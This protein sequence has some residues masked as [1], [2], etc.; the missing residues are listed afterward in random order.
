MNKLFQHLLF[1]SLNLQHTKLHAQHQEYIM[2][3][4]IFTIHDYFLQD[5]MFWATKKLMSRYS[6]HEDG[7][8]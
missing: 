7:P 4:M 1:I 3:Y 5:T 8:A 2:I 6:L